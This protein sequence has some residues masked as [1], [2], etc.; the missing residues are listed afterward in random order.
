MFGIVFG[1]FAQAVSAASRGRGHITCA[2]K[3][4]YAIV[5]EALYRENTLIK[6]KRVPGESDADQFVFY[7]R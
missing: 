4:D 5:R 2:V 7:T 3:T 6:Y 1:G